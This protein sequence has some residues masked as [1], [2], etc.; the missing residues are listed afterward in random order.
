MA[1]R[2][3]KYQS[4]LYL[5]KVKG[6]GHG[7]FC[8]K[9]IKKG[10]VVDRCITLV[11]NAKAL[12]HIDQTNVYDYYWALRLSAANARKVGLK[13]GEKA[14][15]LP[16]GPISY[17]NHADDP[18]TKIKLKVEE[19]RV[20]AVMTAIRDIPA[21]KEITYSYGTNLWFPKK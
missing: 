13:P 7:L 11:F 3:S 9:P 6:K 15:C 17:G 2:F 20:V 12:P 5:R 21:R 10:D 8:K 4:D 14:G 16:M 1:I 18:N 19:G